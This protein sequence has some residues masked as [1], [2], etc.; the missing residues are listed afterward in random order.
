MLSGR[1]GGGGGH[2]ILDPSVNP[3]FLPVREFKTRNQI[4]GNVYNIVGAARRVFC[5][6]MQGGSAGVEKMSLGAGAGKHG[7]KCRIA[8][9]QRGISGILARLSTS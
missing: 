2:R 8:R 3:C 9:A 1:G 6:G 4:I 7:Q 5:V